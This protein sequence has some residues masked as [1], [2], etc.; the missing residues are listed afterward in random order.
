M[1]SFSEITALFKGIETQFLKK[2]FKNQIIEPNSLIYFRSRILF[3][4]LLF[5]IF[6]GLLA[7]IPAIYLAI[8]KKLWM[9]LI[10]DTASWGMLLMLLFAPVFSFKQRSLITVF[11][12]YIIGFFIIIEVG[13][14]SG[15]PTWLF[16]FAVLAG[17]LLGSRAALT[18]I[19]INAATIISMGC[20][21]QFG[22]VDFDFPFFQSSKAFIAAGSNFIFLNAIVAI[23]VA[24]LIKSL[25]TTNL[26]QLNLSSNLKLEQD[27]LV[28]AKNRLEREINEKKRA[29]KNLQESQK[30]YYTLFESASDPIL[31]FQ[32]DLK[33]IDCNLKAV[34]MFESEK[35]DILGSTPEMFSPEVQNDGQRSVEKIEHLLESLRQNGSILFEWNHIRKNGQIYNVEVSITLIDFSPGTHIIAII[36]DITQRTRL[37]EMML[38]NEKMT[39]IGGLAAGMAHEINNPLAGIVQNLEVALNR[40]NGNNKVNQSAAG[41]LGLSM[42]QISAY[43]KMRKIDRFLSYARASADKAARI[44][45]NMLT[46][47]YQGKS[48]IE[49]ANM[50]ELLDQTLE[51]AQNDYDMKKN[52]DFRRIHIHKEYE[53]DLPPVRCEKLKIQQVFFN[54]LKNG[55]HAMADTLRI[56]SETGKMMFILRVKKAEN[57]LCID[58]EDNGPGIDEITARYIFEPFFTTKKVGEGTGLGLWVSYFIIHD[59][60]NGSITVESTPGKG[61][62]FRVILPLNPEPSSVSKNNLTI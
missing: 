5:S 30:K 29:Q 57:S 17:V 46:F 20:L 14:L 41:E 42:E 12:L 54:L 23:S 44:V 6:A 13:P 8:T 58:I 50:C 39:S 45:S 15:G 9:L 26:I 33:I 22:N 62:C 18:A 40:V 31:V 2:N 61:S 52:Y 53:P 25:E 28:E 11:L 35:K 21:M 59:K 36:R 34:K 24:A 55:A 43:F 7:Y 51:L 4:L 16:S 10:I 32:E 60:H 49:P 56:G 27:R 37:H 1:I 19:A 3:S 47:S 48:Q 38:Q